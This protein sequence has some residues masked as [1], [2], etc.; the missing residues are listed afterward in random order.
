MKCLFII[1]RL[2]LLENFE[3][4]NDRFQFGREFNL[5]RRKIGVGKIAFVRRFR[6]VL[7]VPIAFNR[8]QAFDGPEVDDERDI[9]HHALPTFLKVGGKRINIKVEFA[10]LIFGR[11][12]LLFDFVR[13]VL[14]V[15]FERAAELDQCPRGVGQIKVSGL[16]E[17]FVALL[18]CVADLFV[19]LHQLQCFGAAVAQRV[20]Q[21]L[22]PLG[23]HADGIADISRRVADV[24]KD[25]FGIDDAKRV[26]KE[27]RRFAEQHRNFIRR[28]LK[29][30]IRG[31]EQQ[32]FLRVGAVQE[33]VIDGRGDGR[34][35]KFC[36]IRNP[37]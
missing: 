23:V 25:A 35:Q 7:C 1:F 11:A 34:A 5:R 13:F 24:G 12:V 4:V 30:F 6:A 28:A 33:T 22:G 15:N 2:Q 16:F 3:N 31:R 21:K 9:A 19:D 20:L 27:R 36:G 17:Q 14:D 26:G 10:L 18:H 37:Q 29:Q 32:R 8:H